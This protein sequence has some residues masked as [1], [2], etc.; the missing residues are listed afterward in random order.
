MHEMTRNIKGYTGMK[1][2]IITAVAVLALLLGAV[3]F[4]FIF[5]FMG[6]KEARPGTVFAGGKI[7]SVIDGM[8]LVFILDG[9]RG[10]IALIDAGNSA[11]GKPVVD[12]LAAKGYT[13]ADVTAVFLTHGHPDHIAAAGI[14]KNAKIYAL[15]NEVEIAEGIK[16]NSSPIGGLFAPKP[17]GI[18]VT[19]VLDDGSVVLFGP[20]RIETFNV[21]GHTDGSAVYLVDGVL[22]MGDTCLSGSD[23]K[24][25]H[26]VWAFSNS[27]EQGNRSLKVLAEK[28][29]PR[30]DPVINIVFSH[31]GELEGLKPLLDYAAEVD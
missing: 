13:P 24:I 15:K 26:P 12:A 27:I 25:K 9:G 16:N 3:F 7:I 21:P 18:K 22:F 11:D 28:L 5:P 14:F 29:K 20:F 23:G 17:T 6:T 8:S 2:I 1:K 10:Q 4:M 31:S 30:K 19:G